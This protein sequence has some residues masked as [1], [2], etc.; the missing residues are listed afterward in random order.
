MLHADGIKYYWIW[1]KRFSI[2]YQIILSY[3][4]AIYADV[5]LNVVLGRKILPCNNFYIEDGTRS[6]SRGCKDV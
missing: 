5:T 3:K 1:F 6:V 4:S 2:N